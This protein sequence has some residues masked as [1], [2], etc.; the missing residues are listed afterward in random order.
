MFA[1]ATF[2]DVEGEVTD[3]NNF[4][5]NLAGIAIGDQI[6]GF[7]DVDSAASGPNSTFTGDDIILAE[8]N[9]GDLGSGLAAQWRQTSRGQPKTPFA[10]ASIALG[11]VGRTCHNLVPP[12]RR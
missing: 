5:C 4:A 2:F 3:C 7:L 1:H 6:G 9:V 11:V 8:V 10:G 12:R